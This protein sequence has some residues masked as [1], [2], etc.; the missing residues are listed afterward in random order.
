M[1]KHEVHQENPFISL[2]LHVKSNKI[3]ACSTM[4]HTTAW[5]RCPFNSVLILRWGNSGD[6][7]LTNYYNCN[8]KLDNKSDTRYRNN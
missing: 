5:M 6:N 1:P 4:F 7:Y 3:L 2:A 8:T